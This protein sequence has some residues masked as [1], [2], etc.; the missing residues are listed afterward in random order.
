MPPRRGGATGAPDR[1]T[2][3]PSAMPPSLS[4]SHGT[5]PTPLLGQTIGDNLR[6]AAESFGD[7][8]ALV[9]VHQGSRHTY[10]D[11]W[12]ATTAAARGL[13]RLGVKAGDRVGVWSSNRW[14]WVVV[15]YASARV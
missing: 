11:L 13:L 7:R 10:R 1:P 12:D 8:D 6:A 15:Q 4:Y 3:G 2:E 5:G 14:E 9:V